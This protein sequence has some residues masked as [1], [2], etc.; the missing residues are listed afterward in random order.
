MIAQV[1]WRQ[2]L[3]GFDG[4]EAAKGS[5]IAQVTWKH[6]HDDHVGFDGEPGDHTHDEFEAATG[7]DDRTGRPATSPRWVRWGRGRRRG[8]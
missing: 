2:R 1:T 4:D 7:F 5:M 6:R 8:R 3:D